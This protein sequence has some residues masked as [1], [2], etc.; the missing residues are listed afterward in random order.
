M[1]ISPESLISDMARN[2]PASFFDQPENPEEIFNFDQGLAAHETFPGQDLLRLARKVV[3]AD[4]ATLDYFEP[5]VGYSELTYGSK[6]TREL[7]AERIAKVQGKTL[8]SNGLILTSGSVQA[9]ALGARAFVNPGDI[10]AIEQVT[11]PYGARYMREAGAELLPIPIDWNGMD[12]DV[13]EEEIEKLAAQG[14]R[15]KMVY[16][17]P[18]FH[19]PTGA[20]MSLDRRKKL[21]ALAHQHEFM[22]LEDDCYG[23][24]RFAGEPLPS[25]LSLDD[26]GFVMQAGTFSKT[27][28]PALR[29]G[30]M[31]GSP[32]V[33][34]A[35][36]SVRQDLGISQWIAR[37]MA[38]YLSEDL[39]DAHIAKVTEVYRQ[40]CMAAVEGMKTAG[41]LVRFEIPQG[42]FYLWVEI[43]ERV[44]WERAQKEAAKAKI[45]FRP[46][47][48]FISGDQKRQ[49]FRMAYSQEPLER[50]REGAAKMATIIRECAR[51]TVGA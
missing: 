13:L 31:A 47:E 48:R 44:D 36:A 37:L 15:L 9:I 11:F 49:F 41:D 12:V 2:G 24:L 27:I 1:G 35:L 19:C 34:E 8:P 5:K 10:V 46:G 4:S 14:K 30:W 32:K 25:L 21:V 7:I 28:A 45:Y 29:L 51:T 6:R 39:Y 40:K 23:E 50:V 3:E 18:T 22:I 16:V 20:E 33:I 26:R 43:D 42:S 17:G 38:E